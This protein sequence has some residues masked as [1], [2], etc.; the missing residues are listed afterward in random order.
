VQNN[1]RKWYM[2]N[3]NQQRL[4][5]IHYGIGNF[6]ILV[7][8]GV[9]VTIEMAHLIDS[10]MF[11]KATRSFICI[12]EAHDRVFMWFVPNKSMFE[13]GRFLIDNYGCHFAVNLDAWASSA[14]V[15]DDRHIVGPWRRV[16]DGF[17]AIPKREFI[18][19]KINEHVFSTTQKN[20]I[21]FLV[22]AFQFEIDKQW[23]AYKQK[24]LN[25]FR[26]RESST[27]FYPLA[28]RRALLREMTRRIEQISPA[29][30]FGFIPYE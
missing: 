7:D 12:P 6:P 14:M 22:D 2:N 30:E 23:E 24:I 26:T 27:M 29:T 1:N 15:V 25:T 21:N 17:V 9:D 19:K 5:D 18:E 8:N 20:S 13:M 10:K 28:D 16:V 3:T 4:W 11:N